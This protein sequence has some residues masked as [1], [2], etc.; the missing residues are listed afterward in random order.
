MEK[1]DSAQRPIV[2]EAPK[3][4]VD[5]AGAANRIRLS[6]YTPSAALAMFVEHYWIVEWDMRGRPTETQRVLPYPNAHLV[7]SAGDAA[8]YGPTSGVFDRPVEGEGRVLGVRFLAGGLRPY[9][10]GPVTAL[11][12]NKGSPAPVLGDAA[13][14]IKARVLAAPDHEAMI[15]A[16]ED[17][18]IRTR[19]AP[20]ATVQWLRTVIAIAAREHGPTSAEAL[21][22]EAGCSM[23]QLQRVFHDYVGVSPK[24]TIKRFRI[25]EAAW[26]LAHED[27]IN[28]AHLA[29]DLGYFDQAHLAHDFKRFIGCPP[30]RYR[31][32]QRGAGQGMEPE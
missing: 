23:R 26:R 29:G 28:L 19:P 7:L 2:S 11:T 14:A 13:G 32:S 4:I 6:R 9:L 12:D 8:L 10:D 31:E 25:Q 22:D 16:V 3:G 20:D 21:A 1:R 15:A 24:W 27:D 5:P 30:S 17:T 18:M